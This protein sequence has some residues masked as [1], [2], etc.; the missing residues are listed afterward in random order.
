MVKEGEGE[1]EGEGEEGRRRRRR[2]QYNG[3]KCK[4]VE[5]E[6]ERRG[7]EKMCEFESVVVS[8]I[9]EFVPTSLI[10]F[11]VNLRTME[12][13]LEPASC[14]FPPPSLLDIAG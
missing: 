10:T 13:V 5:R 4:V 2:G 12:E 7:G 1:G 6:S 14:V 8:Q 11:F 3:Q 9:K